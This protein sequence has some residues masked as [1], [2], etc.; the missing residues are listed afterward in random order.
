M[1]YQDIFKISYSNKSYGYNMK[2]LF[3]FLSI[4]FPITTFG[5]KQGLEPTT[6]TIEWTAPT[7]FLDFDRSTV[8]LFHFNGAIYNFPADNFPYFQTI[9]PLPG[10]YD[11]ASVRIHD[12]RYVPL[13][14]EERKIAREMSIPDHV[15]VVAPV[16]F[17]RKKPRAKVAIIPLVK[18][19]DGTVMKISSF[20]LEVIPLHKK[21]GGARSNRVFKVNSVLR[22]GNWYKIAVTA[23][24]V[25]KVSYED[26]VALGMDP[27]SIRAQNIRLFG[28]GGGMLPFKNDV[29]RMDDLEENAIL[30]VD[31]DG[32][33]FGS[34]D[35]FLFYGMSQLRWKFNNNR[36]VHIDNFFSDT[37][38]YFI[39]TDYGMGNPKRI[40]QAASLPGPADLTLDYFDDHQL[41]EEDLV[42]FV[43]SGR[44]WYGQSFLFQK[45]ESVGFE[46]PNVMSLQ[47]EISVR[48]A[49]RA[50]KKPSSFTIDINGSQA[51]DISF[52]TGVSGDYYAT[53]ALVK[54]VTNSF[55]PPADNFDV[56]ITY[57]NPSTADNGWLDYIEITAKRR[58]QFASGQLV[59]RN[60]QQ[61]NAGVVKYKLNG[62]PGLK[63]WDVTDPLNVRSITP[64]NSEFTDNGGSIKEYVAFGNDLL[65]PVLK[66]HVPNQ[67]LHSIRQADMVI[68]THPDF[69][70]EAKR[71]GDFHRQHDKMTVL[72]ATTSEV[73]NE[74]SSGSPDITAIKDL[75]KMLY[76][77]AGNDDSKM[78]RYLL[79][80]GDASYDYKDRIGNNTNFVLAY[81]SA[82]SRSPIGSYVSDD[83]FGFLDDTE[84]DELN[85]TLDIGVGRIMSQ[86][87]EQAKNIVDKTIHY[88]SSPACFGPWRTRVA[89]VG[90]DEDWNIHMKQ[91]DALATKVDT[92]YPQYN[93]NKIYLDAYQQVPNA[94]TNLYPDV[95]TAIDN[96]IENGTLL[97]TYVGHGGEL[98]WAHE[99]IL[100]LNQINN[101]VNPDN[102]AVFLTATCEFAR[103]DDPE[104]TSAGEY[105]LLNPQGGGV[106]LF[107]TTRLVYSSPNYELSQSFFKYVFEHTNNGEL[108]R[109]GDIMRLVKDRNDLTDTRGVNYRN[110][111]IL[112]DPALRIA[113]PAMKV[114][115]DVVPDTVKSLQKVTISGYV[116]DND[117]NKLTNFNGIVY[118]V[119]YDKK[120]QISTLNNDGHGIFK[121][122]DQ[123]SAL[124]RGKAS[125]KNGN[126]T[127][128]FI[129]PKD[130]NLKFGKGRISFYAENGEIDAAG[131]FED[132]IIGGRGGDPDADTEGPTVQI[133][134]NNENFVIGGLTDQNPVLLAKIFDENGINTVGNGI[135]HDIVAVIDENTANPIILNDFYESDL[136]S[137]QSGR[138]SYKLSNLSEGKH[139]LR[140]KVWDVYNNPGEAYT[141]FYVTNSE[142]FTIEH[143][144]NYPNPFTTNT[145]FHFDHN[146]PGQELD[147]R[148]QIFTISGKLVKTIDRIEMSDGY[149]VGPI[150]WDGLDQYGD[151]IGK[152]TYIYKIK[153]TNAFG[154]TAEVYEKLVIL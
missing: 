31:Q 154:Q 121:Y 63:V 5:Q 127:F 93:L 116:T 33:G 1:R 135:G 146:A 85:S 4:L 27:A 37:T 34:G 46:F 95:N 139:T 8:R 108:T 11:S 150:Y 77:R 82:N 68:V 140:I 47:S 15:T 26:L 41:F 138:I 28:N 143:V 76:D 23:D 45:T 75:M 38:Y 118:P 84:S 99:Q 106:A 89:F 92:N 115:A 39:T 117:G 131:A 83:Y 90:D 149:H 2:R 137:Y 148:I 80:F 13:S 64:T 97:M 57:N 71:L 98:G 144:L 67:D 142:S 101:Y 51:F 3:V 43:K 74:F 78:P 32:N 20:R 141:E 105:F 103:F 152:G 24:G 133:W 59:F 58:L 147:I 35:Y 120:K 119:I 96:A 56:N 125:V 25:Y 40:S 21:A 130:I 69:L 88:A 136:D 66:G 100:T 48:V 6:Y 36:W 151:K 91:S 109:I 86:T 73:Y 111:S 29:A 124:F 19:D 128:S 60:R 112:G 53:Y 132:L 55:T 10:G 122:W 44:N 50:I 30:V 81:Q 16:T 87:P 70:S 79:L 54:S 22:S 126:F 94:G 18:G 42:N 110:F 129:V 12:I 134:M 62:P 114:A 113:C 65:R 14:A 9:V 17:M 72:V 102:L 123:S 145:A 153:V 7:Q 61:A 49:S 104:R 52:S 107:T